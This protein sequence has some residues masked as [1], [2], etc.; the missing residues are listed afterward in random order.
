MEKGY[1][2]NFTG[3]VFKNLKIAFRYLK[4][5]KCMAIQEFYQRFYVREENINII[6][7]LPENFV[8]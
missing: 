7:L 4:V 6:T 3:S 2:D 1:F 5:E 8:I